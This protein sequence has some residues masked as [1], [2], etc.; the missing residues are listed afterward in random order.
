MFFSPR[1][2]TEKALS[3]DKLA[4]TVL[5]RTPGVRRLAVVLL[6]TACKP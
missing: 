5:E 6:E 2:L 1:H 3:L 4:N